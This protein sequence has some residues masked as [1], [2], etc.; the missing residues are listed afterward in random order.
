MR[1]VDGQ[2]PSVLSHHLNIDQTGGCSEWKVLFDASRC[3][4]HQHSNG[5][6]A[7]RISCGDERDQIPLAGRE[8]DVL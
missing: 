5:L 4:P 2:R 3:V 1:L 8:L 7:L 6:L